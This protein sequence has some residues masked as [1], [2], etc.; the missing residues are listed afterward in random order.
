MK[1]LER[2]GIPTSE[3]LAAIMPSP[4]RL[5]RGPAVVIECFQEIPCDPCA[6]AC[7]RGAILPFSDINN[8]PD[9]DYERCNGC[10]VC[11][12]AC[13][14]CAIFVVD[15]TF[16]D[17][18]ALVSIPFEFLPLPSPGTMVD[19]LDRAGR[20]A[21]Q[22]RVVRVSGG[23]GADRTP[24]ISVAVPKDMGFVVR[25]LAAPRR[26]ASPIGA[27]DAALLH[28][29]PIGGAD[30][31]LLQTPIGGADDEN[32]I[33]CRCEEI[34]L[35][36][37]RKLIAGGFDSLDEIKRISRCGMG[38]CQGRTCRQIVMNEIASARGVDIAGLA[39]TTFRPPA[40]SVELGALLG[41]AAETEGTEGE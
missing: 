6:R 24:V 15:L 26:Q 16:S 13:P 41:K 25:N 39:M 7:P 22:A 35:G 12:K 11:I 8:R 2:T 3:D 30:A 14:G 23:K 4:E 19:G 5:A 17:T 27:A 37:I 1:M 34:T 33:V 21:C 28:H 36:D 38:P 9:V 18:E 29:P 20:P 10:G 31:A 40:K 32:T